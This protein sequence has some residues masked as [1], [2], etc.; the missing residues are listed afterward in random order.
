MG[1]YLDIYAATRESRG[2]ATANDTRAA[3]RN[4]NAETGVAAL[5][6]SVLANLR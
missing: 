4:L 1:T 6:S 2:G 5:V 3:A